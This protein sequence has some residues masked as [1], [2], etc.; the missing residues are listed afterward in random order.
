MHIVWAVLV[1]VPPLKAERTVICIAGEVLVQL[2]EVTVLRYQ[3]VWVRE[4]GV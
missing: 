3:V 1:K 4:G 2:P